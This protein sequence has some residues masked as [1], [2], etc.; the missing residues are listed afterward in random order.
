MDRRISLLLGFACACASG[1]THPPP[2]RTAHQA[3]TPLPTTRQ[4]VEP[5]ATPSQASAKGADKGVGVSGIMGSLNAYEVNEVMQSRQEALLQCVVKRPRRMNYVAGRIRFHFLVDATGHIV[6]THVMESSLGNDKLEECLTEVA[7]GT[8]LP[9]P[10]GSK[11]TEAR[12]ELMVDPIGPSTLD[13]EDDEALSQ[14]KDAI[15]ASAEGFYE[16]CEIQRRR[17]FQV[18]AYLGSNGRVLSAGIQP[19]WRGLKKTQRDPEQLEC[20]RKQIRKWR[21]LPRSK[22][23]RKVAFELRWSKPPPKKVKKAKRKRR[24]RKRK[25]KS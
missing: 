16:D 19:R 8:V 10:A 12:W 7:S 20:L 18:T 11:A 21:G 25:R 2:A 24:K 23:R 6:E 13:L 15:K 1:T 22:G 9:V 14:L 5:K 4:R 3:P 17:R